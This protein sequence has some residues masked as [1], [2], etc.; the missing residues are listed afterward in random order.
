M[1][2]SVGIE[3]TTSS[4]NRIGMGGHFFVFPVHNNSYVAVIGCNGRKNVNSMGSN[5]NGN[6][7]KYQVSSSATSFYCY[8]TLLSNTYTVPVKVYGY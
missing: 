8:A 3:V 7:G 4:S 6:A 1:F 2:F 5:S